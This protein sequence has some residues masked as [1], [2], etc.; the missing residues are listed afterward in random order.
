MR[1]SILFALLLLA[2]CSDRGLFAPHDLTGDWQALFTIPG[3][4]FGFTLSQV[5][6]SVFGS[7][8]YAV[9]AGGSGTVAVAGQYDRP[10]VRLRIVYDVG[11]RRDFVGQVALDRM[12]GTATDSLGHAWSMVLVRQ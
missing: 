9:E 12:T 5:G 4:A 11:L 2:G 7:G 10:E 6:D 8:R 1:A 3:S